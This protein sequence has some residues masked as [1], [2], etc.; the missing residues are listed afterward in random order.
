MTTVFVTH[1]QEEAIE[2][3]DEIVV[4]AGGR[5]VQSGAP[6]EL[7]DHPANDFVMRFLGPVTERNG[8]LVRPHDLGFLLEPAP[9]AVAAVVRRIV[10]SRLR[11]AG[12]PAG[13]PGRSGDVRPADPGLGRAW[14]WLRAARSTCG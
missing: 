12:R 4:L 14:T 11:G 3:S 9:E 5:I 10:K 13:Q 7:Y 1:D 8:A 2:V 6:A